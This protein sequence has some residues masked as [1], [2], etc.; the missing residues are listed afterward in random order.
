MYTTK[1]AEDKNQTME[2]KKQEA[3]QTMI[4]EAEK[5]HNQIQILFH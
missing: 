4:E 2:K 5:S 1:Y 3:Q